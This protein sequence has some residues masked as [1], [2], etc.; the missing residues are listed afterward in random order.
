MSAF[1]WL[2]LRSSP[3]ELRT[4]R[5]VA[6]TLERLH[7]AFPLRDAWA[8]SLKPFAPATNVGAFEGETVRLYIVGHGKPQLVA[9][10][11]LRTG[12]CDE[13]RV[14]HS[15]C[16]ALRQGAA[17][18]I[19]PVV[20]CAVRTGGSDDLVAFLFTFNH[21]TRGSR[22]HACLPCP[23]CIPSVDLSAGPAT[24]SYESLRLGTMQ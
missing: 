10:G 20:L 1:D 12:S 11:A 18:A 4:S 8:L 17:R 15:G 5:S 21:S 9:S 2:L 6:D 23:H 22:D 14:R 24:R 13:R 7:E 16:R 3:M 19:F